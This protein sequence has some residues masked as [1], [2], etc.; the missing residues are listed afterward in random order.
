MVLRLHAQKVFTWPEWVEYFSA[1]LTN[2]TPEA[3][4]SATEQSYYQCWLRALERIVVKKSLGSEQQLDT[5]YQRWNHAADTTPHG[6]P[7]TLTQDDL[8]D[9]GL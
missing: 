3:D 7:I 6:Q 8:R 2:T 5:L 1:E 4:A 9:A